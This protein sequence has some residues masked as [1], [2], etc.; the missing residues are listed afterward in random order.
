LLTRSAVPPGLFKNKLIIFRNEAYLTAE[1]PQNA[2]ARLLFLI[3]L[4]GGEVRRLNV[5]AIIV[6]A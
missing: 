2:V 3:A 4:S 6:P 1:A 5:S